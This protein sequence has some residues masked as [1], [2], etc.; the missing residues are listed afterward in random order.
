MGTGYSHDGRGGR[1]LIGALHYIQRECRVSGAAAKA[2]LCDA[3]R[4]PAPTLK[5]K[6]LSGLRFLPDVHLLPTF[7]DYSRNFGLIRA[8]IEDA[9]DRAQAD[10]SR[11]RASEPLAA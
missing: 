3:I 7:N 1:C 2:Y 9:R 8:V 4:H 11:R 6:V 10:L 5:N